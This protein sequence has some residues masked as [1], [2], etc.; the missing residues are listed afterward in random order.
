MTGG[1]NINDIRGIVIKTDDTTDNYEAEL[2]ISP[3]A[4][5]LRDNIGA[6]TIFTVSSLS[7][8]DIDILIALSGR[9]I[10]VYYRD[11]DAT[12]NKRTWETAG[13]GSLSSGG[14]GASNLNEVQWGHLAWSGGPSTFETVWVL[15][16][17]FRGPILRR[18]VM[19]MSQTMS[20]SQR[21]T[22]RHMRE[23]PSQSLRPQ[24]IGLRM[25]SMTSLRRVGS[26]GDRSLSCQVMSP[27][28]LSLSNST[29]T[30]LSI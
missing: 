3:T 2:R 29:L 21:Q 9:T 14:G 25:S 26:F 22:G 8:E 1:D 28:N 7:L 15:T 10:T 18:G 16:T 6:T 30:P 5:V 17:Y 11:I 27:S 23:I 12:S 13:T 20:A 24:I 19:P 4:L